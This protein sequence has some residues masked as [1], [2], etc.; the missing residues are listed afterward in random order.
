M[1]ALSCHASAC[2]YCRH[3]TPEGRRGGN[4]QQLGV[5]VRGNWKACA[6]AMPP[7]APS[8]ENSE[9][10]PAWQGKTPIVQEAL[11]LERSFNAPAITV[12][13]TETAASDEVLEAR[14]M[15]V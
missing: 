13:K 7:F 14:S 5:P 10:I 11:S 12:T 4:C 2:R 3:F 15:L 6:L 8:W 9:V 1:S